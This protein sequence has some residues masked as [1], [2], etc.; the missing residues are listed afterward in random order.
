MSSYILDTHTFLWIGLDVKKIPRSARKLIEASSSILY[1]SIA[2]VWELS[3]KKSINK[4][5]LPIP[6]RAFIDTVCR[7]AKISLLP[8]EIAHTLGVEELPPIHGDPFD[9]LLV[10]QALHEG[11]TII[12][13]DDT[14]DGYKV[15]RKW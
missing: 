12:S 15:K 9:R 1:L 3:I 14:F 2:S 6:L 8:I 13:A 7:D 5:K 4:V 11:M 10:S